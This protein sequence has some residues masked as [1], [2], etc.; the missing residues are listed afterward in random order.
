MEDIDLI[1]QKCI[2]KKW[3]MKWQ[4]ERKCLGSIYRPWPP[5]SMSRKQARRGPE[6]FHVVSAKDGG[7]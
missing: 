5:F 4:L 1:I 6:G 7:F 3:N 2:E